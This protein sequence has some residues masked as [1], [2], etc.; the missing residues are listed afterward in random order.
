[1]IWV[2]RACS[3]S[4]V[5]HFAICNPFVSSG[6]AQP[7]GGAPFEGTRVAEDGASLNQKFM[8]LST[9]ARRNG[10]PP[11]LPAWSR[12]ILALGEND[13][14][15]TDKYPAYLAG[16][17]L[18]GEWRMTLA[19]EGTLLKAME[20]SPNIGL[21]DLGVARLAMDSR[22]K[23]PFHLE[24][25]GVDGARIDL[26]VF[27]GKVV[28]IDCWGIFCSGCIEEFPR[29]RALRQKYRSQGFEVVS[30]CLLEN[31]KRYESKALSL[32][33]AHIDWPSGI[34]RDAAARD[35]AKTHGIIVYP[36][37][38]IV[39]RSGRLFAGQFH[40]GALLEPE[41]RRALGLSSE[42][43]VVAPPML[44]GQVSAPPAPP[45]GQ[46]GIGHQ[47]GE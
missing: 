8:A 44:G 41:I 37:L 18:F 11:D 32:I 14:D 9:S 15:R 29:I 38:W 46:T 21:H 2:R 35:F 47:G 36:S 27:Q 6:A 4:I 16:K 17:F 12:A 42:A 3:W 19:D 20:Q 24:M 10:T 43:Q 33:Q 5:L 30:V 31:A 7:E 39:D 1:M 23:S 40:G 25:D 28:L 13:P 26:S 34:I 22:A 45:F